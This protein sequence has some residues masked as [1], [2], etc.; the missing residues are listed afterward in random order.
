MTIA[1]LATMVLAALLA[2][3][4][5][6]AADP[7]RAAAAQAA[8][9]TIV[10]PQPTLA[11]ATPTHVVVVPGQT[12]KDRQVE[13]LLDTPL[14]AEGIRL[15]EKSLHDLASLLRDVP[16]VDVTFDAKS[17]EGFDLDKPVFSG[18][19]AGPTYR[20]MLR[21]WLDQ[22]D[23]T[24]GVSDGRVVVMTKEA[25]A[26]HLAVVIYP[27]PTDCVPTELCDLIQRI[28]RPTTWDAQGGPGSI[29]FVPHANALF[30]LQ[31]HDVH[32]ELRDLLRD[33]FD[34]DLGPSSARGNPEMRRRAVRAHSITD[35]TIRRTL[36]ETL[37]ELCNDHLG[38]D[39]DPSATVRTV[40]ELLLVESS[41]R[42]FQV[43][44]TE[45]IRAV[46][47]IEVAEPTVFP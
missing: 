2:A 44:A 21:A 16:G 46:V 24:F 9:V 12:E 34:R 32:E 5:L 19:S 28:I 47:G 26:G 22:N 23:I 35:A 3:P 45:L 6:Q 14:P 4:H 43:H 10:H 18:P 33:G 36:E 7:A 40:G 8:A 29:V 27:L 17:L 1:T 37:V 42:P 15:E 41:S 39:A 20:R 11:H 25:A 31:T 13:A 30:V 38:P